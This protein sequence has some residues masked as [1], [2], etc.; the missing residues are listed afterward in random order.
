MSAV[1]EPSGLSNERLVTGRGGVTVA[2]DELLGIA[3]ALACNAARPNTGA[4]GPAATAAL[5]Q[6]G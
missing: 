5:L 1:C 3:A 6:W 4:C 2:A